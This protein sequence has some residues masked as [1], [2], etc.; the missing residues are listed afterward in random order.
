M[1]QSG[2]FVAQTTD[3]FIFFLQVGLR[4][5]LRHKEAV[6]NQPAVPWSGCRSAGPYH[7]SSW[8]RLSDRCWDLPVLTS[9]ET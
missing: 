4:V 1:P 7:F 6:A 8:S 2:L 5:A 3:V 9:S